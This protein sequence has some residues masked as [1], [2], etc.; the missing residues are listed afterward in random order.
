M[1]DLIANAD[2]TLDFTV[3]TAGNVSINPL[4]SDEAACSANNKTCYTEVGFSVTGATNGTVT[5]GTATGVIIGSATKAKSGGKG[6]VLEN[7]SV[8]VIISGVV[9]TTPTTYTDTIVVVDAGQSKA[10]AV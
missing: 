2:L 1:A 9:G 7:D 6:L 8:D 10:K 3:S 4:T 5:G